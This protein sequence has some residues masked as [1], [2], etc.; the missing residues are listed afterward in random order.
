MEKKQVNFTTDSVTGARKVN[1]GKVYNFPI[2]DMKKALN[3]DID[4]SM[5]MES[6]I[7]RGTDGLKDGIQDVNKFLKAIRDHREGKKKI[8][9]DDLPDIIKEEGRMRIG[10]NVKMLNAFAVEVANDYIEKMKLE[11]QQQVFG[12][13]DIDTGEIKDYDKRHDE[14]IDMYKSNQFDDSGKLLY[15]TFLD[16]INYTTLKEECKKEVPRLKKKI[17]HMDRLINSYVHNYNSGRTVLSNIDITNIVPII[18][19]HV[20]ANN[21]LD[22]FN[23]SPEELEYITNIL[24]ITYLSYIVDNGY[25][26]SKIEN[27]LYMYQTAKS[28]FELDMFNREKDKYKSRYIDILDL[29]S[30]IKDTYN[31]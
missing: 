16:A 15:S 20:N 27:H 22:K 5:I 30:I 4:P 19:R 9:F 17:K 31:L 25:T 26:A 6:N 7:L 23:N 3:E 1:N 11:S 12:T 21:D 29:L 18:S 8:R 28:F 13:T 14:E 2:D 10:N 24:L